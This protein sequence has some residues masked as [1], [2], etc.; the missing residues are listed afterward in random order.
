M[1]KLFAM[2]EY[3]V[4]RAIF[5]YLWF[6]FAQHVITNFDGYDVDQFPVMKLNS[7]LTN[8]D[9]YVGR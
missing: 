2:L 6:C 8:P 9:L 5:V 7:I 1:M 3:W 4:N